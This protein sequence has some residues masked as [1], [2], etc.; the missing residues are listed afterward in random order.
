MEKAP[1]APNARTSGQ[2]QAARKAGP[3]IRIAIARGANLVMTALLAEA[4]GDEKT[5]VGR[6]QPTPFALG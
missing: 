1:D 3:V 4:A 5:I 2:P 6:G